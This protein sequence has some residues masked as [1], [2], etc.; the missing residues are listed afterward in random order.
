MESIGA[1]TS[2]SLARSNYAGFIGIQTSNKMLR[3]ADPVLSAALLTQKRVGGLHS[4]PCL[5]FLSAI[6][7]DRV[8]F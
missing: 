8:E 4:E 6:V 3:Y 5:H 1:E 7:N 2:G